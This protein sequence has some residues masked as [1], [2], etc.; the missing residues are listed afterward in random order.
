MNKYD[1]VALVS[2]AVLIIA[3][4]LYAFQENGRLEQAQQALR[5]QLISDAGE[6]YAT[7]C[8]SCHGLEGGGSGAVPALNSPGLATARFDYLHQR[9]AH[10]PHGSAMAIWHLDEANSLDSYEVQ[11]LIT[12]IRYD[13]WEEIA[14]T[15]ASY[16]P[17]APPPPRTATA[18]L[19]QVVAG[20]DPHRCAAC[21]QEPEIHNERFGL[22]C[23]RCHTL[24]A[25]APAMLTR[26]VFELDHG[27]EGEIPCQTCH[28][29]S[30]TMHTCYGCHDHLPSEI[31]RVH[32]DEGIDDYHDCAECHPTGREGEAAEQDI[33]DSN[34]A[35]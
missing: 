2:L 23:A 35:R 25:W 14:P 9:I 27:G 5:N 28:T 11:A 6:L 17:Q 12:L 21:H 20:D 32:L 4:P 1:L 15:V 16:N 34:Y 19:Q 13:G 30:Y 10:A 7:R 33:A 8:V 22:D 29:E 24:D 31:R 18:A 26:H 3:V